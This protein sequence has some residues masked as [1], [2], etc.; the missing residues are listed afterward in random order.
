MDFAALFL[1]KHVPKDVGSSYHRGTV[2]IL[3]VMGITVRSLGKAGR[4][5]KYN[6]QKDPGHRKRTQR[7]Q[8]KRPLAVVGL[9]CILSRR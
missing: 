1:L 5:P 8:R 2:T 4:T 7:A 6:A 9:F 3:D